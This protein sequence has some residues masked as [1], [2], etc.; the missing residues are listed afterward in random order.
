MNERSET[1]GQKAWLDALIVVVLTVATH[2]QGLWGQFVE[3]DD[4]SHITRNLAI[5][6]LSLH[7][8]WMMFTQATAKLYCPL[9]W[10]S[11][12]IDYQIWGRDPFGYHLT[13]LILHVA[14]TLLV[15]VLVRK[16]L[17]GRYARAATAALVTA[18]IFGVHP[19]H[20]E[21]VAWAT[22]RKDVLFVFFYLLG[23]LGYLR[24]LD[25]RKGIDYGICLG[26]FVASALSK[27]TAVTFPLVLLLIDHF[28]GK[29]KAWA[30]KA[31]FFAVSLAITGITV[32][33]QAGGVGE[34]VAAPTV[35]PL[36]ARAGLV[37]YC[38]L[39]YVGKFFWPA[40]LSAVYPPF[41]DMHWNIG[42]SLG[43]LAAF[44]FVTAVV[45]A[46]RR[47]WPVLLP[48]WLFYLIALSPT[49]GLMPVGI[50]VVA[51]RY[52]HLALLGL[53]LPVGMVIAQAAAAVRGA[54]GRIILAGGIAAVFASLT[55]QAEARTEVWANTETL[56]LNALRENPDCL[57]AHVNL[58]YWYTSRKDFARAIRHGR[59]AI[60]IAPDGIPGRK[61]LAYAY[62]NEGDRREAI[63]VLRPLAQHNVGDPDVWRALA[64]CFDALG[65]T[66]NAELARKSARELEGKL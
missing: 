39:F 65:D 62:I 28:L 9:T 36:W 26:L 66:N 61:N 44:V 58:T 57:P 12:A 29:R 50:H 2:V 22:E 60:E 56:F 47:R 30:E 16:V 51:D 45:F 53:M 6:S 14:N 43:Y 63:R 19:L 15:L 3:W 8:L 33:C 25:R 11:F 31:P 21:S 40:H 23:L 38:S 10:L 5:R 35:I 32:V 34:T 46:M 17:E 42:V 48:S 20:V 41:D 59:R 1:E 13:N 52:A 18:V 24:W 49:I 4:T 37:G 64:E 54:G 27:S 55:L 7:N